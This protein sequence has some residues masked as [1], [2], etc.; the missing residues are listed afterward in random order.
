MHVKAEGECT[1]S[2]DKICLTFNSRGEADVPSTSHSQKGFSTYFRIT[3]RLQSRKNDVHLE[4]QETFWFVR[5]KS[6]LFYPRSGSCLMTG[7]IYHQGV[8]VN[9]KRGLTELYSI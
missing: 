3:C 9:V 8:S 5:N 1:F 2:S 7:Q 6:T 4:K